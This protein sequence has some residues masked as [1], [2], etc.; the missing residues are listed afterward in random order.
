MSQRAFLKILVL[1]PGEMNCHRSPD[2]KAV[3]KGWMLKLGGRLDG[4][5]KHEGSKTWS[6]YILCVC[7]CVCVCVCA[8]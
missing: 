1:I 4:H 2:S 6:I 7:V 5:C 8:R 3:S